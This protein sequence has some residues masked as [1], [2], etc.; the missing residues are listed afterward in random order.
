MVGLEW[1]GPGVLLLA[2]DKLSKAQLDF[3]AGRVYEFTDLAAMRAQF[4]P[5]LTLALTIQ[6]PSQTDRGYILIAAPDWITA[7]QE[8]FN[9]WTPEPSVTPELSAP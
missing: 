4:N 7:I 3:E 8:L 5:S 2:S 6:P 9:Q 1:D